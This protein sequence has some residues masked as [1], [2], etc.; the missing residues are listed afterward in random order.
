[1]KESVNQVRERWKLLDDQ[2]SASL[3]THIIRWF[4]SFIH[5]L[6]QFITSSLVRP[7]PARFGLSDDGDACSPSKISL[8]I[9]L[10]LAPSTNYLLSSQP[11]SNYFHFSF[12]QDNILTFFF[13]NYYMIFNSIF[14]TFCLVFRTFAPPEPANAAAWPTICL[15]ALEN[16]RG[17]DNQANLLL[18]WRKKASAQSARR[19]FIKSGGFVN[20]T[21]ADV[22][23]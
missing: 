4:H 15:A 6:L 2:W 5:S 1:M 8:S 7:G 18:A 21:V 11:T 20:R 10:K 17:R 22:M 19:W 16:A 23:S 13:Q 12:L 14:T 9:S 3:L